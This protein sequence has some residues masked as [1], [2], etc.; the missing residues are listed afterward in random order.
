MK[1]SQKVAYNI[2]LWKPE[3]GRIVF[4]DLRF[5]TSLFAVKHKPFRFGENQ[6]R[7]KHVFRNLNILFTQ[8]YWVLA[9]NLTMVRKAKWPE[10][11]K[12]Q[13]EVKVESTFVAKFLKRRLVFLE[14]PC[15]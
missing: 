11:N 2:A 1:D 9:E 8:D 10:S 12:K 14:F 7:K 6:L 5:S 3:L 13:V 15:F 4:S